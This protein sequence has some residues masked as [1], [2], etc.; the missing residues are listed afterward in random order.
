MML[1][2]EGKVKHVDNQ[3]FRNKCH[4]FVLVLRTTLRLPSIFIFCIHKLMNIW[5]LDQ[6]Q[7]FVYHYGI[8]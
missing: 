4:N 5:R 2:N 7:Q 6:L 1:I 8:L 3:K